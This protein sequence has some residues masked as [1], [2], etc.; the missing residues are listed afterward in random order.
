MANRV[1]IIPRRNDLAG[2]GLSLT[3]LKPNAGQRN[4]IYD[5]QHQNV[6]VTE[7]LDPPG[8]TVVSGTSYVSGSKNTTLTVNAVADNTTGGGNDVN[9]MQA[10][11]FGLA[12]YIKDRVHRAG[13]AVLANGEMTFAECNTVAGLILTDVLAGTTLNLARINVHLA[14]TVVNTDLTG[15]SGNSVSF[16]TVDDIMRILS[17]EVYRLP[18]LTII[19]SAAGAFQTLAQ[20]QVFVD[21]QTAAMV[22]AQGQFVASGDFLEADD[23]GYRARPIMAQSGALNASLLNGVLSHYTASMDILNTSSFAYSAGAVTAWKPRA[24]LI[25][26]TAIATTGAGIP[27]AVYLNDGTNLG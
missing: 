23:T 5:G 20:R 26:G 21:A 9:A 10:T 2:V 3:D 13:I 14:A 6:Y 17:G 15:A 25:N 24:T 16:G 7:S 22:A 1:F 27:L 8:A 4:S 18:E 19:E 11:S 12:S